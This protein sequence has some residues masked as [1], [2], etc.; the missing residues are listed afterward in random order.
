MLAVVVGHDARAA[1]GE[2]ALLAAVFGLGTNGLVDF[3]AVVLATVGGRLL[4]VL[5]RS[6][7]DE[8]QQAQC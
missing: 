8:C 5:G 7:Q 6:S 3:T 4:G 1:K 2:E